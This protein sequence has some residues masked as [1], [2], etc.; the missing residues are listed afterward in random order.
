M[1]FHIS[2]IPW[3][4]QVFEVDL[5]KF[6]IDHNERWWVNR[7]VEVMNVH[8]WTLTRR[9]AKK[10]TTSEAISELRSARALGASEAD[11][12]YA[13]VF[14]SKKVRSELFSW[15]GLT[16]A[17]NN[18]ITKIVIPRMICAPPCGEGRA[19]LLEDFKNVLGDLRPS[20]I[21]EVYIIRSRIMNI[22]ADIDQFFLDNLKPTLPQDSLKIWH[23]T[24]RIVESYF[25]GLQIVDKDLLE[26]ESDRWG[27]SFL[28][29][30][31]LGQTG[32]Y[33]YPAKKFHVETTTKVGLLSGYTGS[34]A[35]FDLLLIR[36]GPSRWLYVGEEQSVDYFIRCFL[37]TGDRA[38]YPNRDEDMWMMAET[39]AEV[40]FWGL[41]KD[42]DRRTK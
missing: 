16:E 9:R 25:K 15:V 5:Q 41:N 13:W 17:E 20:S 30:L 29:Y 27:N 28:F 22:S 6:V 24:D 7:S 42:H 38:L 23:I 34:V 26:S 8:Q 40:S 39:F 10:I 37:L 36:V 21:E 31:A 14:L 11:L 3:M 4:S 2:H 18:A 1:S 32:W 33:A 19:G 35:E 12:I